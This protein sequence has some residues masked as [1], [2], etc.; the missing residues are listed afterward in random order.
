MFIQLTDSDL[1]KMPAT[2]CEDFLGWLHSMNLG[3]F[4]TIESQRQIPD[5]EAMKLIELRFENQESDMPAESNADDQNRK[6]NTHVL[7]S[8][9]L[10]AGITRSGMSVRIRLKRGLAKNVGRDYLNGMTISPKGSVLYDGKEF[11]KPS[12]LASQ[13]NSGSVNGW[14]YI[15]VKKEDGW[16]RLDS[17]RQLVR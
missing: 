2:L 10:D 3:S 16:V 5:L 9:L 17:L 13:L 11:D 8:Q 14:E 15:E 1:S 12:P 7:L 6:D 4:S